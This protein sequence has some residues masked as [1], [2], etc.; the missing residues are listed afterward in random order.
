MRLRIDE[1]LHNPEEGITFLSY[2][3]NY[4]GIKKNDYQDCPG[5]KQVRLLPSEH[6]RYCN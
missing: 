4:K 6:E 5:E 3:R 1:F 2:Y